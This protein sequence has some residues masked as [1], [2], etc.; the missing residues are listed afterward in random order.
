[1]SNFKKAFEILMKM[2]FSSPKDFLHKNSGERDY[3]LAGIYKYANPDWIGWHAVELQMMNLGD[4][5]AKA[6]E[7]LYES[8]VVRTMISQFYEKSY[9]K[10][11]SLDK[12][13]SQAIAEELFIF[14][15]NAGCRNAVRKA[16]GIIGVKQ[17]GLMGPVTISALN[18]FD[19]E[20]FDLIFDDVEI[21]YYKTIIENNPSFAIFEKG[22]KNRAYAV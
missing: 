2:E 16:Q 12:I 19:P 3:T 18:G 4:D 1:M 20:A 22:W 9:W 6:S 5:I 11:M 7:K 17:D 14:G 15:V 13:E 21:E 8:P 10:R